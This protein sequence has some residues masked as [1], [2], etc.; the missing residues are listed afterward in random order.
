M[1]RIRAMTDLDSAPDEALLRRI[2][3]GDRDAMAILFRRRQQNVYR[4]ALHLT[5]S[6]AVADDVTQDVFIAVIRDA[7]RFEPGRATADAWLCGIA[8]NFVRRRLDG[9]RRDEPIDEAAGAA[10]F[11]TDPIGDLAKAQQLDTLRR[12]LLS[13]PLRY[14]EVVVLCD[15]HEMAYAD[16]AAALQCAVGTVRSR[17]HRARTL[18]ALKMQPA[19][20]RRPVA[21]GSGIR[22]CLA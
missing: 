18:L 4:F 9:R 16:A 5:G 3:A 10:A 11:E 20:E 8:R 2:A 15:L 6:P 22:K 1:R 17:L 21:G 19:R 7:A 12:A 13:L 14:R